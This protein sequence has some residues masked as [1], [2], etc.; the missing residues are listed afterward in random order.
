VSRAQ[1]LAQVVQPTWAALGQWGH[2]DDL[3][4]GTQ[5]GYLSAQLFE[6]YLQRI[7]VA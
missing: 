6:R 4:R 1:P 7:D 5:F 2:G 3:G